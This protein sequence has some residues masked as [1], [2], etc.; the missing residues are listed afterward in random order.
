M[1]KKC[2]RKCPYC[3]TSIQCQAVNISLQNV[4]CAA[5]NRPS[6]V[7]PILISSAAQQPSDEPEMGS[8]E[9]YESDLNMLSL[10]IK[11]LEDERA[12]SKRTLQKI[13]SDLAN[14]KAIA[15]MMAGEERDVRN[16]LEKAQEE[17]RRI[18]ENIQSQQYEVMCRRRHMGIE[19][20]TGD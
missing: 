20:K 7:Q 15:E 3:R 13:D 9:K 19:R 2:G 1:K 17:L 16:R 12:E 5:N 18:T 6:D 4:I 14:Q 10:R 8:K 11:V